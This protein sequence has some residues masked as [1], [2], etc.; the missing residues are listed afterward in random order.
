MHS[1]GLRKGAITHV[2]TL[3][4]AS[5]GGDIVEITNSCILRRHSI[6]VR[7]AIVALSAAAELTPQLFAPH[8]LCFGWSRCLV[9]IG[10]CSLRRESI[11][12]RLAILALSE[13]A[14][15]T[16]Q[17]F[18]PQ[19]LCFGRSRRLVGIWVCAIYSGLAG[20]IRLLMLDLVIIDRVGSALVTWLDGGG[21]GFGVGIA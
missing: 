17:L 20:S 14:E 7:L 19:P 8:P 1:K 2:C 18:V 16:P 13:A 6:G 21:C 11:M 4:R 12:V 5:K 3:V 9:G 15:M 10:V